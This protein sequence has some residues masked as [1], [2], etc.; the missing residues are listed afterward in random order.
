[1]PAPPAFP[2]RLMPVQAA[3]AYIGVSPSTLRTLAIPRKV[4][5]GKRLYE[6]SDLDAYA[7]GLPY[8]DEGRG[9]SCDAL[10][11]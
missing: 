3:A 5:G 10:L 6:R 7:D 4:A 1:M 2:P 11:R 9:N 8:E